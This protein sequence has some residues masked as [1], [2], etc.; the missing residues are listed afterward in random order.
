[1]PPAATIYPAVAKFTAAGNTIYGPVTLSPYP[2]SYTGH[3]GM[4]NGSGFTAVYPSTKYG[5]TANF[6]NKSTDLIA[7]NGTYTSPVWEADRKLKAWTNATYQAQGPA[8]NLSL[9]IRTGSSAQDI[10][11]RPWESVS[12]GGTYSSNGRFIQARFNFISG[13]DRDQAPVLNSYLLNY[14]TDQTLP[15]IP[16]VKVVEQNRETIL[17]S[18]DFVSSKPTFKAT[19][20]DDFNLMAANMYIDNLSLNPTFYKISNTV[21]EVSGTSPT[22]LPP[23]TYVLKVDAQDDAGNMTSASYN[24]VV[25]SGTG[26]AGRVAAAVVRTGNVVTGATIGFSLQQASD[27]T[28]YVRDITGKLV[29]QIGF[30]GV[31][32]WNA[33]AWDLK[34]QKGS[35]IPNGTYIITVRGA[36]GFIQHGTLNI[37]N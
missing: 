2:M 3:A 28:I 34:D 13:T 22:A 35:R 19:L 14:S 17:A 29:R 4:V 6:V 1:M 7:A 21:A 12:S 5:F 37:G 9:Q 11:N 24:V 30:S 32:G 31:T 27:G 23:G 15:T 10:T 36:A 18:G 26:I 16:N 25:A 33:V 8:G 20:N